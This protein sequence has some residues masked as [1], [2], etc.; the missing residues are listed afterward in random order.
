MVR[1]EPRRE[2]RRES[3]L[4]QGP[5]LSRVSDVV[6]ASFDVDRAELRRRGSR[7]PVRAALAYLARS[8]TVGTNAELAGVLG[9]SRSESVPNLTR[10]FAAWL[11]SDRRV[12]E[13][14]RRLEAELD[15]SGPSG[16][17]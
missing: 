13:Q 4:M 15:E 17:T 6:C 1:G 7:H 14:L 2:R 11:K 16:L 10:R 3:P 12:R 9:L 8:R 5:T